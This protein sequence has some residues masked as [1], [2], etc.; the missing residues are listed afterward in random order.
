MGKETTGTAK[1]KSPVCY[2]YHDSQG[3]QPT[4]SPPSPKPHREFRLTDSGNAERF[5][6]QHGDDVR[7]VYSWHKWL[8][9]DGKRWR[10]DAM[11]AVEQLAK[12]TVRRMYQDAGT[13]IDDRARQ[14]LGTY[15]R[16][17]ESAASRTNMVRLARSEPPIPIE[18]DALDT[19]PWLLNC[20]NGT[21]DL[22]TGKLREHR[23]Q[24]FLTKLAPVVYDSSAAAP[25]WQSFLDRIFAE[26]AEMIHFVQ[27]LL[28]YCITG[29]VGEQV[30][31]ILYGT[32]ANGKSTLIE[33][34]MAALGPDYSAKAPRDLLL[35]KR[36]AHPTELTVLHGR[37]LVVAS[38]TEDGGRLAEAV[39][40][41]STGGDTITARRMKEDFWQFKPT[42]KFL[43]ATNHRPE[44]RGTD[45]A[46]WRRLL[47]I[48]FDVTIPPEERDKD[49]PEKLKAELPG[50]LRWCVEGCLKWKR[51]SLCS[52]GNVLAAT[53]TY[54]AEQDPLQGF[55]QECCIVEP[56]AGAPATDLFTAY[57]KWSGNKAMKQ[58]R[59]GQAL[60]EQRMGSKRVHGRTWRTGVGLLV[61]WATAG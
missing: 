30:L 46:I 4:S 17:S 56:D 57:Q 55:L 11:A 8:V 48:P 16:K 2:E 26:D 54:R 24:D 50:I 14:E 21:L 10:G 31:P 35:A 15:A 53:N 3:G 47:L 43:L 37:R 42:H 18:P 29:H 19:N 9:W 1:G 25:G 22:K 41:E 51:S 28:G 61:D 36:N 33:T 5:A 59:F 7:Y 20:E 40:K 27:R 60:T 12:A 38:E 49:L 32:G 23:R 52:P 58:K 44:V 6:A 13:L 34:V 45:N 39:V